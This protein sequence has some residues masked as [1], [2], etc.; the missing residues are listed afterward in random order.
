[1]D[2]AKLV[3]SINIAAQEI[4]V[5]L[6][7][8]RINV[9]L[10]NLA[11]YEKQV[12]ISRYYEVCAESLDSG[13][14]KEPQIDDLLA[15]RGYHSLRLCDDGNIGHDVTVFLSDEGNTPAEKHYITLERLAHEIGHAVMHTHM[16]SDQ[17]FQ[18]AR[19]KIA[20][21]H[22]KLEEC[23]RDLRM[24]CTP[25]E[26]ATHLSRY[27]EK[28]V[29]GHHNAA[30]IAL[31][32]AQGDV[33]G[34]AAKVSEHIINSMLGQAG[35]DAKKAY[36][37]RKEGLDEQQRK[38]LIVAIR[39]SALQTSRAIIKPRDKYLAE[40]NK[41]T[42]KVELEGWACY[43][44][45]S[46]LDALIAKHAKQQAGLP[47][48]E[49]ARSMINANDPALLER[50]PLVSFHAGRLEEWAARQDAYGVGFRAYCTTGSMQE[51]MRRARI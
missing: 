8:D 20:K 19:L 50:V 30:E 13:E 43:F 5:P 36:D 26:L 31:L 1:M 14:L 34:N 2:A 25:D 47:D 29:H 9:H 41:I 18:E 37:M 27:T 35:W 49:T 44:S 32:G 28:G 10:E 7:L 3:R 12:V 40:L 16:T 4:G 23:Y 21:L 38:E 39:N 15:L 11:E 48:I 22:G 17:A 46:I 51:A 45:A 24:I 6:P 33:L 42:N